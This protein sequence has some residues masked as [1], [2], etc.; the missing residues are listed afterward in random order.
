MTLW[1]AETCR[2]CDI[3]I[4]F[5]IIKAVLDY[6]IIYILLIIE[7]HNGDASPENHALLQLTRDGV[8]RASS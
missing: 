1:K 8:N 4:I 3:L 7:K 6:K 5:Y 2:C